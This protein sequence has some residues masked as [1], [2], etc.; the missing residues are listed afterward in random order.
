MK[1]YVLIQKEPNR[2]PLAGVLQAIPGVI[3]ADDISGAYDAIALIRS[4]SERR[5]IDGPLGEILKV[6]GVTRALPAPRIH[7]SGDGPEPRRPDRSSRPREE[8]IDAE[9]VPSG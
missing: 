1:A 6:P 3:S 5:L 9:L 4:G 7:A 8:R 2:G